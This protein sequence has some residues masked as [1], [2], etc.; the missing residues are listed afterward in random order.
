M[1]SWLMPS[2]AIIK[3]R[4]CLQ[5]IATPLS[6][7]KKNVEVPGETSP[8]YVREIVCRGLVNFKTFSMADSNIFEMHF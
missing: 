1:N 7:T 5:V 3:F 8:A 6:F 2:A 4:T